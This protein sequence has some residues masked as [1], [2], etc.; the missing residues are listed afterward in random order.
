MEIVI[1]RKKIRLLSQRAIYLVDEQALII[2]D[3]HLGKIT[4]FRGAGIPA[5]SRA[6]N[7]NF[8]Q[9]VSAI[10]A[11]DPKRVIFLG[12]LF[13]SHYNSDWEVFGE[14]LS[15]YNYINFELVIGNHDIMSDH[16]YVRKNIIVH[17]QLVL[18]PFLLTHHPL[19]EDFRPH[20]NLAGHIHPGVRMV[21][22][23]RQSL[24]LPCFFF[25]QQ[26][27]FLPAFGI[28]TGFKRIKPEKDDKVFV[29]AENRI[30]KVG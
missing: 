5:P 23:G 19:E 7:R 24:T 28:F 17:E 11:T 18:D 4:H 2:A 14:F 16:Q 8:E 22:G 27:G 20:Y 30:L 12:D 6:G 29:I 9:L 10:E 3:L 26:Q 1:S 15:Y 21:G 13:H 25:G